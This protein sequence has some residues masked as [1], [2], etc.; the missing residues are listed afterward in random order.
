M[1][2][3][4]ESWHRHRVLWIVLLSILL[5]MLVVRLALPSIIEKIVESKLETMPGGYQGTIEDVDVRML[6]AEIGLRGFTIVK[7]N[8]Q[9]P[10]PF[11][12]VKEF[13]LGT[14]MDSWMPRTVLRAIEPDASFVDAESEAKKQKGPEKTIENLR[15]QLP[16]ELLRAEVVDGV[17]HFRNF[18]T[19]PDMDLYVHHV[20]LVWDKLVG[21]LPPGSSACRSKLEGKAELL[22]SGSLSFGGTFERNPESDFNVRAKLRNLRAPELN[23]VLRD[24]ARIKAERGEVEL[25]ARYA[26][27]GDRHDA[28]L[29]PLLTDVEFEKVEG[30]D[31]S[32]L[33]ELGAGAVAG[34]FERKKG[35]K[36][37]AI[38][39]RPSGKMDF[40]I[41]D[42]PK[43]K[44]ADEKEPD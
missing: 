24:Y 37:V 12:R 19:K 36:G 6:S 15:K 29:V 3:L 34:W 27:R 22:K 40:E 32:F 38:S 16:F 14:V 5:L 8:G 11:M 21:C 30:K 42:R 9:V 20:N 43:Q 41:V 25:D 7:K 28:L 4:S 1:S 17:F 13:V 35:E 33:I 44:S 2:K 23:P 31:K 39:I 18:Q 10:V 26:R